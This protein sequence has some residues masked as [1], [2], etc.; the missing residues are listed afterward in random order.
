MLK[1]LKDPFSNPYFQFLHNFENSSCFPRFATTVAPELKHKRLIYDEAFFCNILPKL[2]PLLEKKFLQLEQAS[3]S[4][5][6]D[7]PI[8]A[9]N[10]DTYMEYHQVLVK[11]LRSFKKSLVELDGLKDTYVEMKV[12]ADSNH[13][14]NPCIVL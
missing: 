3:A 6:G 11:L 13:S 10:K 5:N 14:T 4:P 2:L 1:W 12:P 7:D 9:Y 8:M